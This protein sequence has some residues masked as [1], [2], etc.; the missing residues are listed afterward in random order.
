MKNRNIERI[1]IPIDYSMNASMAVKY[2]VFIA[3]KINAEV[4][5]FHSFHTPIDQTEEIFVLDK[6][7]KGEDQKMGDFIL[8]T[9]QEFGDVISITGRVEYGPA[10]NWICKIVKFNDVD[11]IV[12]GTKGQTNSFSS[13][14]G[15]VAS[16]TIN[17]VK[18]SV[19]VIP[20]EVFEFNISEVMFATDYHLTKENNHSEAMVN[21]LRKFDPTIDIVN[22]KEDH[23]PQQTL[24]KEELKTNDMFEGF[25]NSMHFIEE[26]DVEKGIFDF[27]EMNNCDLI[28]VLTKHYN[29]WQRIF[30]KSLA[31]KIALH[32]KIPL[33]VIHEND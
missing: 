3:Q 20:Q 6:V 11:L 16:H 24:S 13:V 21:L 1:L 29:I 33:F 27:V 10:E 25:R 17:D 2:G 5:L 15:S 31:K 7:R 8:R 32:S 19:L 30:H 9:K 23:Y 26:K 4:L 14:F 28:V 22:F 12:M 18:C